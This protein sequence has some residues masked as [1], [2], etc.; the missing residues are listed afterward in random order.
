M[1][2]QSV[3]PIGDACVVDATCHHRRVAISHPF[4]ERSQ[5]RTNGRLGIQI[6][7]TLDLI[8]LDRLACRSCPDDAAHMTR[9]PAD[10]FLEIRLDNGQVKTLI[11]EEVMVREKKTNTDP[12]SRPGLDS[13]SQSSGSKETEAPTTPVPAA[14]QAKKKKKKK[15]KKSQ[16]K[17]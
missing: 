5:Q 1:P 2:V 10:G 9:R 12:G 6:G 4:A 14:G 3:E 7:Q 16:S 15:K 8:A 13:H 17:M 11:A